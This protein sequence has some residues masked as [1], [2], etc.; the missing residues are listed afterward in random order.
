MRPLHCIVM[1]RARL[2]SKAPAWAQLETA[3]ACKKCEPGPSRG[4]TAG[5]GP[6]Q[7]QAGASYSCWGRRMVAEVCG[8]GWLTLEVCR[9]WIEVH[10]SVIVGDVNSADLLG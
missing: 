7:A 4:L 1:C 2:G 9:L 8:C 5:S 3:W 6:A 10:R